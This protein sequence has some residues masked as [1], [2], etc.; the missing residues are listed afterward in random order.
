MRKLYILLLLFALLSVACGRQQEKLKY[1]LVDSPNLEMND[2]LESLDKKSAA[3]EFFEALAFSDPSS[4]VQLSRDVQYLKWTIL[5][6]S[7]LEPAQLAIENGPLRNFLALSFMLIDATK[8]E[9][10]PFT[11]IELAEF[12]AALS[13]LMKIVNN[14]PDTIIT[15]DFALFSTTSNKQYFTIKELVLFVMTGLFNAE[16]N[17]VESFSEDFLKWVQEDWFK[18]IFSLVTATIKANEA[19]LDFIKEKFVHLENR[20]EDYKKIR[21]YFKTKAFLKSGKLGPKINLVYNNEGF[22]SDKVR[23]SGANNIRGNKIEINGIK[24][25]YNIY[26]PKELNHDSALIVHVYGGSGPRPGWDDY[27]P[28]HLSYSSL[29]WLENNMVVA[30]LNLPDR[31]ARDWVHQGQLSE[32]QQNEIHKAIDN[33]FQIIK[34]SPNS[35]LESGNTKIRKQLRYLSTMPKYLYGASFGG[36]TAV[37]HLQLY[38]DTFDGAISHDGAFDVAS[39][40]E[41]SPRYLWPIEYINNLEQ[42]VLLLHNMDDARVNVSESINFHNALLKAHKKTE[43]FL[44]LQ[45]NPVP[46]SGW[47]DLSLK[48]H[49]RPTRQDYF[50]DYNHKIIDFIKG[51]PPTAEEVSKQAQ[52]I[53]LVENKS[54]L[55]TNHTKV[56]Y[57]LKEI[58][59]YRVKDK[60]L[61]HELRDF[62][63]N[64]VKSH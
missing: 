22:E 35:L 47:K 5:S 6:L 25:G 46:R 60:N 53:T 11:G 16:K 23:P 37:R 10:K 42:R 51:N 8:D 63:D 61:R 18:N 36:R 45:G 55:K 56:W 50:R 59:F 64:F 39:T 54:H 12:K 21:R 14:Q 40:W 4:K 38:P 32:A 62:I 30:E 58:I 52:L 7:Y 20:M 41:W 26:F 57:T 9:F 15:S 44:T 28:G 34:N 24:V 17:V 3:K 33:F 43:L 19:N 48:G 29:N 27:E 13:S 49:G 2:Y 1:E 31:F